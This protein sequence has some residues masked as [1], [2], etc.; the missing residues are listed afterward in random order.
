[1][2][3]SDAEVASAGA[4]RRGVAPGRARGSAGGEFSCV[5]LALFDRIFLKIFE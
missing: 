4:R 2:G 5:R 3:G 1:V